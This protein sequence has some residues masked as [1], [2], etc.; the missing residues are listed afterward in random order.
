MSAFRPPPAAA[1]EAAAQFAE[2]PAAAELVGPAAAELLELLELEAQ[3]AT[4]TMLPTAAQAATIALVE[5]KV[6]PPMPSPDGESSVSL[7]RQVP[8][9]AKAGKREVAP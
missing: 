7:A 3:P 5:R 9:V 6:N 2:L 1:D 8:I 4:S